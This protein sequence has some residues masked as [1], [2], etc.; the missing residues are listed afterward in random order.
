MSDKNYTAE[1]TEDDRVLV[2]MPGAGYG[3]EF[4]EARKL[5]DSLDAVLPAH[6]AILDELLQ[7]VMPKLV[8]AK[9]DLYLPFLDAAMAKYEISTPLRAAAFLAQ[10]AH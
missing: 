8:K 5:R 3:L 1:R 6:F 4:D 9:R 10:L 2:H 7:K